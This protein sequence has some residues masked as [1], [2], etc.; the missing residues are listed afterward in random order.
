MIKQFLTLVRLIFVTVLLGIGGSALAQNIGFESGNLSNWTTSGSDAAISTGLNNVSYGGG[1]TWT[2][3]PYGSYMA[4]LYP[5]GAVQFDNATSSLG[6]TS[7]DNTAIRNFMSANAGGGNPTPTNASWIKRTVTL[8]AGS[9]YSFAWNYLSTDYTPYNDGSMITLVHSSD[10]TKIPTLNNEQKRYALLGFTN[11]GTGNYSTG[12]Y[13]STGWQLAVFTVP[14]TGDYVLGFATFNLGDTALSP[15]LFIDEVQGTTE[16]NGQ[17]FGPIAPNAGSSAPVTGGTPTV[18][19][20]TT[21][22]QVT[23]SSSSA[24]TNAITVTRP[25]S[26]GNF[27]DVFVGTTTVTTTTTTPVTTTTYSDGST[28]TSNGTSSSSTST[29]YTISPTLGTAP[30]YSR[31]TPNASGNSIY[32]KQVYAG[33]NTS[34]RLE[35][36]GNNNAV[37]GTDSGWATVDG[38]NSAIDVRQFGQSNIVG[39]KMN[40]WGNNISIR[41]QTA[42][43]GDV[44]NNILNFESAGNGNAVTALQQTNTNTASIKTTWDINT[45]NLTQKGGTGNTSYITATGY[46]NTVNN[47]QNGNTNFSLVNISGDNNT[48]TVNQTGNN[49]ST[50][51]NLIGNKNSVS[52]VQTGT[53]DTYSLQQTCTNP[54]GCSVSVIRN[55]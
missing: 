25:T 37:T 2:I 19:S 40:A 10:L 46:W 28:T 51:L 54:A 27:N 52:V 1:K 55:K 44:G 35:Q 31:T 30:T 18:V 43:G 7:T 5:S 49:H 4:Q 45:V 23:T 26:T 21:S 47:T 8:Q 6:L 38:N 50:L 24:N 34:V 14:V 11:P 16:L 39:L 29:T 32:V 48:A 9:T 17:S 42:S 15:M 12:S 33:S 3:K 41:Q 36:D 53:G 13:G 20:T 22:N